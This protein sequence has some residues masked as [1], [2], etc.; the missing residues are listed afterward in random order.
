[1]STLGFA[2]DY[3]D[4]ACGTE[5]G[6]GMT[7]RYTIALALAVLMTTGPAHAHGIGDLAKT[8][9]GN[10]ATVQ[11]AAETCPKK[12]TLSPEET[13]TLSIARQ[14]AQG[15][16]LSTQFMEFDSAASAQAA[17]Q[18]RVPGFCNKTA[19][20]KNVLLDAIK[21]AGEKLITAR[22]LGL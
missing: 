7:R 4:I 22:V 16:L 2:D 11:K 8:V 18:A 17:A 20:R 19:R 5:L 1:M 21:K 13:I 6:D 12:F 14:A 10:G 3:C 9:L 15:L